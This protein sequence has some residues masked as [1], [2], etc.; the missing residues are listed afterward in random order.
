MSGSGGRLVLFLGGEVSGMGRKGDEAHGV[1]VMF[2]S[3]LTFKKT[4]NLCI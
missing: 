3:C 1:R 2:T 4:K